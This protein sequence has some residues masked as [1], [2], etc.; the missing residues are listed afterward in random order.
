MGD[1]IVRSSKPPLEGIGNLAT[2]SVMDTARGG[3]ARRCRHGGTYRL[4]TH[5]APDHGAPE[6]RRGHGEYVDGQQR[7]TGERAPHHEGSR[8]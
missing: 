8:P 5:F 1:S 7:R 2:H 3:Y 6:Q 4:A